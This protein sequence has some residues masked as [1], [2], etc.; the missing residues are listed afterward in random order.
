MVASTV[1]WPNCMKRSTRS[2]R[3]STNVSTRE[4]RLR[5]PLRTSSGV[6]RSTRPEG[7]RVRQFRVQATGSGT[8]SIVIDMCNI[9]HEERGT[10]DK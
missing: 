4:E 3:S 6:V 5:E 1:T 10:R 8:L 2:S 7:H 9:C